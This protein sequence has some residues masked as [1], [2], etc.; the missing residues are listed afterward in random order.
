MPIG[1]GLSLGRLAGV[2]IR[3]DLSL[4]VVLFLVAFG[5]AGGLLPAWH[6]AWPPSQRWLVG[7]AAA[8]LFFASIVA[9][10][11]SHA[12][13]AR[14]KGIGVS[15]ITLFLFGGLAHLEREPPS[16]RSE[17]LMAAAGPLASLVI[18]ALCLGTGVLLAGP[19]EVDALEP[20]VALRGVGPVATVLLWLGPVNLMLAL[21][22]LVPGFPLDGGRMLRAVVWGVT[23]NLRQATRW[24]SLGGRGFA[25]VLIGSGVFM[26]AGGT[27]PGFGSGFFNGLWLVLIGWFLNNAALTGYRQV[28]LQEAL[29]HMPVQ[30]LMRTSLVSAS[31]GMT[32]GALVDRQLISSGQRSFPVEEDGRFVGLVCLRDLYRLPREAWDR[33][34]VGE[35]MIPLERLA[36]VSLQAGAAEALAVLDRR[37]VNQLPVVDEGRFAGL[38]RRDDV[39]RWLMLQG[40]RRPATA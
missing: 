36:T 15:R 19:V 35:V 7:L 1:R 33:V 30:R 21:F 2:E 34:S 31:P 40:A 38:V 27:V 8:V 39:L 3:A 9:H 17:L 26:G 18:G 13:V 16:W 32:V 37:E 12:L 24:A 23:G 22:N 14:A 6:P 29:E 5:L 4:L 20:L 28:V 10:E 25:F 11:L